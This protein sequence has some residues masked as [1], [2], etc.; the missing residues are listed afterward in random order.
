M[1]KKASEYLD[2]IKYTEEKNYERLCT[3]VSTAIERTV[4]MNSYRVHIGFYQANGFVW[5][6][7]DFS[8]KNK[9]PINIDVFYHNPSRLQFYPTRVLNK[10]VKELKDLG[11]TVFYDI[12]GLTIL[13]IG[14]EDAK[15]K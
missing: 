14:E 10:L 4:Y 15:S 9:A 1:L 11:Y 8:E 2:K 7:D 3:L 6:Q 12:N 13:I 5:T